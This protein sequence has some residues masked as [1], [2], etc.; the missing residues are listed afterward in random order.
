MRVSFIRQ[1]NHEVTRGVGV[2][3]LDGDGAMSE[4]AGKALGIA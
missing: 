4:E 1:E 2:E 3:L